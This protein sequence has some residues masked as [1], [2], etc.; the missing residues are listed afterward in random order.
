MTAT[1]SPSPT[2][3]SPGQTGASP[4]AIGT[5][6]SSAW[7]MVR[8]VG[9]DGR[10]RLAGIA[11]RAI[12]GESRKPPS[13]TPG[14]AALHQARD[15]DRAGGGGARVLAAVDH[16]D[17]ARRAV[18]DRL[19]VWMRPVRERGDRVQILPGRHVA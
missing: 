6:M 10:L 9:A 1:P 3:T 18:L 14:N 19:A 15:E 16:E 12:S 17:R 11:S 13:V 2:T 8:F 5:S 7:W 4:Q